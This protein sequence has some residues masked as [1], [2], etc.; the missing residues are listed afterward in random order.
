M[1][2]F[3]R[4]CR[5]R[6]LLRT[7]SKERF[8]RNGNPQCRVRYSHPR[9]EDE[10]EKH[11]GYYNAEQTAVLDSIGLVKDGEVED[12]LVGGRWHLAHVS[13]RNMVSTVPLLFAICRSTTNV[14][15]CDE[16]FNHAYLSK[17]A[18]GKETRRPVD[19]KSEID[20]PTGYK[21]MGW[22]VIEKEFTNE[23]INGIRRFYEKKESE[24]EKEEGTFAAR[25]V[26][27]TE[28]V[29]YSLGFPYV[30]TNITF[31]HIPTGP[32]HTRTAIT[33]PSG[34]RRTGMRGEQ[35][36]TIVRR[37]DFP[38]W[39]QFTTSQKRHLEQKLNS[40]YTADKVAGFS[41]RAPELMWVDTMKEY[42]MF[43]ELNLVS[44]RLYPVEQVDQ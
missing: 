11:H 37:V 22:T 1:S 4:G 28:Q 39:R 42:F 27:L 21:E 43:F 38:E 34:A 23:K 32:A 19:L 25:Q 15:I 36:R 6:F 7:P 24:K 5:L 41:M 30:G 8:R 9:D 26:S 3:M 33:K 2:E 31:V 18:A 44:E 40:N 12:C 13:E 35:Y 17:Y 29:W 20:D 14:K 10:Y 16:R